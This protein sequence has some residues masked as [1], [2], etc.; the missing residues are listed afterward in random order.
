MK[1]EMPPG[2]S[3]V[4]DPIGAYLPAQGRWGPRGRGDGWDGT[5]GRSPTALT[6][7]GL[8]RPNQA[9]EMRARVDTPPNVVH[10]AVGERPVWGRDGVSPA[11]GGRGFGEV[12]GEWR[13]RRRAAL[14]EP[15]VRESYE[16][17]GAASV[18]PASR[19]PRG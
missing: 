7:P 6:L 9:D 3:T 17:H 16:G 8:A 12:Q 1:P 15:H 11:A 5:M 2:R 18:A 10:T 13:L 14:R 19:R 4:N